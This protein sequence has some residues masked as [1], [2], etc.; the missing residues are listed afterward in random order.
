MLFAEAGE[1][2]ELTVSVPIPAIAK[3][4]VRPAPVPP[5]EPPGVRVRSY[6]LSVCPR[7]ELTVSRQIANSCRLTF[8]MPARNGDDQSR[9][10]LVRHPVLAPGG[11]Q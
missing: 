8:A 6:G 5:L 10:Q 4:A 3:L 11:Q 1:R 2:M 9:V 7:I